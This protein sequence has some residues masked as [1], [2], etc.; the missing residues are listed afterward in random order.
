M[1]R[2]DSI[3]LVFVLFQPWPVA[4]A[5]PSAQFLHIFVLK[6]GFS[7]KELN[8]KKRESHK[9][10]VPLEH[11]VAALCDWFFSPI[12]PPFGKGSLNSASFTSRTKT[13]IYSNKTPI[14]W[15]VVWPCSGPPLL[16]SP[17]PSFLYIFVLKIGRIFQGAQPQKR[18]PHKYRSAAWTYGDPFLRGFPVPSNVSQTQKYTWTF[19]GPMFLIEVYYN[20]FNKDYWLR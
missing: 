9:M 6:L 10:G 11:M 5:C 7:L 15:F 2:Q 4:S 16:H 17:K 20:F 13:P 3:W 12:I 14:G 18:N 1:F 19:L 8:H